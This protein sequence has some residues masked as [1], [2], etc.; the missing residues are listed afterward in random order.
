MSATEKLRRIHAGLPELGAVVCSSCGE[1]DAVAGGLH[2]TPAMVE[3]ACRDG[4]CW[5]CGGTLVV[6]RVAAAMEAQ[7]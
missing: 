3:R 1:R 7:R 4:A 5:R 6:D 2:V